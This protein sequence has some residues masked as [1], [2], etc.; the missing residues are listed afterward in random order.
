[1]MTGVGYPWSIALA[2]NERLRQHKH[3]ITRLW[4][5]MTTF[6]TVLGKAPNYE[7]RINE[8]EPILVKNALVVKAP[9]K[10]ISWLSLPY[11]GD[12]LFYFPDTTTVIKTLG[13]AA[14]IALRQKPRFGGIRVLPLDGGDL[15]EA[16][17]PT[18]SQVK[19][20]VWVDVDSEVRR[21]SLPALIQTNCVDDSRGFQLIYRKGN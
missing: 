12:T 3:K 19:K 17:E 2:Q 7:L 18:P 16:C 9:V 21:R 6:F 14:L 1:M 5:V 11:A 13:D 10:K 20:G 4:R 15:I 8:R